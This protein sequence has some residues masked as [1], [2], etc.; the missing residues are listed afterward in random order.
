MTVKLRSEKPLVFMHPS[1]LGVRRVEQKQCG[2]LA[3]PVKEGHF[4]RVRWRGRSIVLHL[5]FPVPRSQRHPGP[6]QFPEEAKRGP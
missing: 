5:D 3:L 4:R 2:F 1:T 6:I